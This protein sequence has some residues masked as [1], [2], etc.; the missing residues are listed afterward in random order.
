MNILIDNL[1]DQEDAVGGDLPPDQELDFNTTRYAQED[2]LDD[3]EYDEEYDDEWE[4]SDSDW[5]LADD[6]EADFEDD[7]GDVV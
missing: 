3:D 2:D 6:D 5:G 1:D 4:D 7:D